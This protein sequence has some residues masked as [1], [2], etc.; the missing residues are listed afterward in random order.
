MLNINNNK[1][2]LYEVAPISNTQ[3]YLF[4]ISGSHSSVA[5]DSSCLCF[6]GTTVLQNVGNNLPTSMA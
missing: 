3:T 6:E 1:H 2:T 5:V 4:N